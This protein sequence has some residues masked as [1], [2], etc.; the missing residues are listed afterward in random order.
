MSRLFVLIDVPADAFLARPSQL[1]TQREAN[2]PAFSQRRFQGTLH[3]AEKPAST[4]NRGRPIQHL[5]L[6]RIGSKHVLLPS[7]TGAGVGAG[8]GQVSLTQKIMAICRSDAAPGS[9]WLS[10][11]STHGSRGAGTGRGGGDRGRLPVVVGRRVQEM[12][13]GQPK[14]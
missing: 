6:Q 3:D 12:G 14:P 10:L 8:V 2:A 11:L 1:F 9:L 5:H 7:T 4:T 13:F